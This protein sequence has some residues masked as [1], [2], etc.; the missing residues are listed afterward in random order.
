MVD[1]F[2]TFSV[3][4][5]IC[6]KGW[7]NAGLAK[8]CENRCKKKGQE[9]ERGTPQEPPEQPQL[10]MY[11]RKPI[12]VQ[13]YQLTAE[14]SFD[15]PGGE[16][17]KA[18]AGWWVIVAPSGKEKPYS[19]EEFH[20]LFEP[21]KPMDEL[22]GEPEPQPEIEEDKPFFIENKYLPEEVALYSKGKT[23]GLKIL[24]RLD[25]EGLMVE[26]GELIR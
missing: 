15:G 17:L 9:A 16:P 13:A 25:S 21:V 8:Q 12:Y 23:I 19:P 4:C 2:H 20:R 24:G 6:Q 1:K 11:Q 18:E 26:A 10:E 22:M 5:P 7:A 3:E 14:K